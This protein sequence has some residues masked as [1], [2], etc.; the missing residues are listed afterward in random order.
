MDAQADLFADV[1]QPKW[2]QPKG[3]GGCKRDPAAGPG[4]CWYWW[5]GCPKAAQRGCYDLWRN[6]QPET[7]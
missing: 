4:T 6:N 2:V 5:E 1:A 3:R 7:K